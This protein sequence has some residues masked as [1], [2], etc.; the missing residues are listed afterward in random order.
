M[1]LLLLS[2]SVW[3]DLLGDE[4]GAGGDG[5]VGVVAPP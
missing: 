5:D 2:S 1:I 4:G 3:T